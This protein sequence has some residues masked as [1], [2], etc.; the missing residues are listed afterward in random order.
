MH[1]VVSY[2]AECV[3]K[4]ERA[5]AK[6]RASD[7]LS[8]KCRVAVC[9]EFRCVVDLLVWVLVVLVL[10]LENVAKLIRSP[11]VIKTH[12]QSLRGF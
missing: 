4:R 6:E 10:V 9:G 1:Q 3:V 12:T 8:L 2:T 7:E 11:M 5:K